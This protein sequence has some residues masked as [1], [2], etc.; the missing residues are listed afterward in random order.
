MKEL[1]EIQNEIVVLKKRYNAFSKFNYRSCEDILQALKP[2][3][4]KYKCF[5]TLSDEIAPIGQFIYLKSTATITNGDGLSIS[6]Y[7]LARE[8]EAQ[9][10]MSEAQITGSSSSYARK[11]A[12]GGMFLIDDNKDA[13]VTSNPNDDILTHLANC[14]TSD[15]LGILWD[16]MDDSQQ[17]KYKVL[18][19]KRKLEI[20]EHR[21]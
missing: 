3:L 19:S 6:V 8:A 14:S 1:I 15:D 18:F 2:L 4:K 9:K 7:G 13:D 12:L 10:G 16:S 5:L 21:K 17:K 20:N 11:Y